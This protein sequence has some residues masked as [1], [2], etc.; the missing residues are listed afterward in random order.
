MNKIF[1]LIDCSPP[2]QVDFFTDA[3]GEKDGTGKT[4]LGIGKHYTG[5]YAICI[6]YRQTKYSQIMSDLR[7][8][9]HTTND[10]ST[11]TTQQA[12]TQQN[13]NSTKDNLKVQK[14]N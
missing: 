7:I 1:I 11:A 13:V 9:R 8:R 4:M 2:F 3:K 5:R 6:C 12:T 10:N 14:S